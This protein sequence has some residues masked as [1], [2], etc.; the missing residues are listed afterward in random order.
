MGEGDGSRRLRGLDH[1][2]CTHARH[3]LQG[4]A[5]DVRARRARCPR[6]TC[7]A[8]AP[9]PVCPPPWGCTAGGRYL[10]ERS[11]MPRSCAW[12]GQPA[13]AA[14]HAGVA[15]SGSASRR[16]R[17]QRFSNARWNLCCAGASAPRPCR[18]RDAWA[19]AVA[20]S[21]VDRWRAALC[22]RQACHHAWASQQVGV[23]AGRQRG[24]G[25]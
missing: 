8:P 12:Q 5:P 13:A 17:R 24:G 20:H 14:C 22:A 16:R 25:A 15:G 11:R 23:R 10:W 4:S 18:E 9:A 6:L 1:S 2:L 3:H 19:V 7:T 21:K